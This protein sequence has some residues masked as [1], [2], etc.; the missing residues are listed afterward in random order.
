MGGQRLGTRFRNNINEQGQA[1]V[2][3][4]KSFFSLNGMVSEVQKR[5]PQ[6][7]NAS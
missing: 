3:V 2:S 4:T 7:G 1:E 6:I 5:N